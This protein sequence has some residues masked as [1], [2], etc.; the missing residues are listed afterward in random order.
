MNYSNLYKATRL[1]LII[2]PIVFLGWLMAQDLVVG[3]RLAASYDFCAPSPLVLT[4]AP[5][6][7]ISEI[8]KTAGDCYQG[9]TDSPVYFDVRLPRQFKTIQVSIKYRAT[10]EEKV[11]LAV[12]YN[13]DDWRF[14]TKDFGLIQDLGNGWKVGEASFD[15]ADKRFAYQKYQLM[16][17][18]PEIRGSGRE[19]DISEIK[20]LATREPLTWQRIWQRLK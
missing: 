12:F 18:L 15:L 13:K 20:I 9:L 7:R 11:Q 14:E 2:L 4:L 6:A 19:V 16:I 5:K 17:S 10:A 1:F 8:K 3:G